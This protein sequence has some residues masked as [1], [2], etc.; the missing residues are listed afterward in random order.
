M[1]GKPQGRNRLRGIAALQKLHGFGASEQEVALG[2]RQLG[3]GLAGEQF[4]VGADF[5][6]LGVYLDFRAGIV[7]QHVSLA[8]RAGV[9]HRQRRFLQPV[10]CADSIGLRGLADEGD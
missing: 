1:T 2:E 6:G 3:R 5:V 8:D 10:L 9:L 7:E 4:T